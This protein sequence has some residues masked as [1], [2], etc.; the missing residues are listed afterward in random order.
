MKPITIAMLGL[1]AF[2]FV[3]FAGDKNPVPQSGMKSTPNAIRVSASAGVRL[4]ERT[5]QMSDARRIDGLR[6]RSVSPGKARG[7]ISDSVAR[8]RSRTPVQNP[9]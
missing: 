9:L 7:S 8:V 5:G 4:A 6:C 1:M 3:A 2:A